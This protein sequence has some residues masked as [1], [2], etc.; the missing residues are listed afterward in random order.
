MYSIAVR[1]LPF[2]KEESKGT[3]FMMFAFIFQFSNVW[4]ALLL[5]NASLRK[6]SKKACNKY[7]VPRPGSTIGCRRDGATCQPCQME[8][9]S[10]RHQCTTKI[11]YVFVFLRLSALRLNRI[12]KTYY[13]SKFIVC[14]CS[15]LAED[16]RLLLVS[17]YIHTHP[18]RKHLSLH[19]FCIYKTENSLCVFNWCLNRPLLSILYHV[20]PTTF[21]NTANDD[22]HFQIF[23][24]PLR[25][26][27][28]IPWTWIK[29][30]SNVTNQGLSK[31]IMLR[32]MYSKTRLVGKNQHYVE[33]EAGQGRKLLYEN[34]SCPQH[35]RN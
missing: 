1:K 29:T 14:S 25:P 11:V 13:F 3:A 26:N 20:R 34:S 15:I 6:A 27:R 19:V 2:S 7:A 31:G 24:P 17:T 28:L 22:A 21:S 10:F 5:S 12:M 8:L 30:N 23:S 35:P 18:F 33:G 16:H 32:Y 9:T 4:Q